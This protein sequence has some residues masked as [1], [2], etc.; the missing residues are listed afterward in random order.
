ML[1]FIRVY[2]FHND[3]IWIIT[4]WDDV[5]STLLSKIAQ[6]N[7][8]NK[9]RQ[10]AQWALLYKYW[11]FQPWEIEI[12]LKR[13]GWNQAGWRP[14]R[15]RQFE[16]DI[17]QKWQ[18]QD[19]AYLIPSGKWS[20]LTW[21]TSSSKGMIKN[22]RNRILETGPQH[23]HGGCWWRWKFFWRCAS[24]TTQAETWMVGNE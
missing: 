19:S 22:E 17:Q 10:L 2:Y 14:T 24:L 6:W 8:K 23:P 16:D 5:K 9:L 11:R 18:N 13:S 21:A 12:F 1:A 3:P 20:R 15:R 7:G 4:S